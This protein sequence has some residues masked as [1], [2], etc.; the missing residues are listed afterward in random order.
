MSGECLRRLTTL[1]GSVAIL[2]AHAAF[3]QTVPSLGAAQTFAVLAGSSVNS[4]GATTLM[5]DLGVSP[6]SAIT[7]FPPGRVLGTTHLADGIA[8]AAQNSVAVA[9]N[10]LAAQTCTKDFFGSGTLTPGVYCYSTGSNVV[11]ST[12]L[13]AQGDPNAIFIFKVAGDLATESCGIPRPCTTVA[14]MNG[15][16]PCNVF[17]QVAGSAYLRADTSLVGNILALTNITLE[18]GV[19][20]AG[21]LLTRNGSLTLD[22][23]SASATCSTVVPT[24][25][26]RF[27]VFLAAGLVGLGYFRLRGLR[28]TT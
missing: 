28:P 12:T 13:D 3:A 8:L 4:T 9:Y 17:W 18:P 15:G 1:M 26:W 19:T 2:S 22:T 14:L 6:G 7:G 27:V 5:G 21:R 25:P 24:L 11:F 10:A 23:S 16:S 20:V